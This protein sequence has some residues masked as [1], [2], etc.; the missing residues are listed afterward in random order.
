MV[1]GYG[2]KSRLILYA[3]YR[4]P[5]ALAA[6]E[7]NVDLTVT[8]HQPVIEESLDERVLDGVDSQQAQQPEQPEFQIVKGASQRGGDILVEAVGYSYG[9]GKRLVETRWTVPSTSL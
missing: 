6:E 7:F 9:V 3:V 4:S 2:E 1:V 8:A 5:T